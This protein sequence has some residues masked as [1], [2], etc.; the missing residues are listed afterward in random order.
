[1]ATVNSVLGPLDCAQLGFT[2]THEHVFT[3]S[4]GI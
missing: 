2:L 4:A 1:M 3:A